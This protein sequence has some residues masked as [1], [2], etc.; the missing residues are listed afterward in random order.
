MEHIRNWTPSEIC[1]DIMK[2][3]STK[4]N[5]YIIFGR[6]GPTGKTRLRNILRTRGYVVIEISEALALN[7]IVDSYSDDENHYIIDADRDT[8]VIVLNSIL[9]QFKTTI[10]VQ[11]EEKKIND[12]LNRPLYE[13]SFWEDLI[14]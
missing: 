7:N 13:R 4:K 3:D 8:V 9:P 1:R 10:D 11:T 2:R 12:L 14:P 6:T 5:T